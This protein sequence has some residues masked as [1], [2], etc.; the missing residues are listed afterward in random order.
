M[1][2]KLAINLFNTYTGM[3]IDGLSNDV[4]TVDINKA[5]VK[6]PVNKNKSVRQ[7]KPSGA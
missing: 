7:R 2:N 6:R 3:N 5:E 4:H 1:V